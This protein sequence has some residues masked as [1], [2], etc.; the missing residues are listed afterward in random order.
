VGMDLNSPVADD[1]GYFLCKAFYEWH[2]RDY[3]KVLVNQFETLGY[4]FLP[5]AALFRCLC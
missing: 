1:W 4:V 2:N 3:G 5:R